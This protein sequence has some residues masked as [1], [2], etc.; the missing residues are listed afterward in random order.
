M[1]KSQESRYQKFL[2]LTQCMTGMQNSKISLNKLLSQFAAMSFKAIMEQSLLMVKQ[3]LVRPIPS[4]VCLK[5][6]DLRELCQERL[7]T[8]LNRSNV[9]VSANI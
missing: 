5:T 1:C 7:K 6:K 8:Y 3:E 9:I 2:H 4:V